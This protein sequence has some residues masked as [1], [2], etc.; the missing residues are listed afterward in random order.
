MAPPAPA[1]FS[2]VWGWA[3]PGASQAFVMI[4]RNL[5]HAPVRSLSAILGVGLGV[6]ILVGSLWV[7]PAMEEVID[8]TF[9]RAQRQ[10]AS[11]EFGE[12]TRIAALQEVARLPAVMQAEPYRSIPVTLRH[13][14]RARRV[15]LI[16][17][18]AGADLSRVL[19]L[20]H[21]P[22]DPPE[23]G[24]ALTEMLAKLLDA[25][26]GDLIEVEI[27]EGARRTV[28]APV[29]QVIP[30]YLGLGAYV[31]L[32]EANR[33]MRE[34]ALITGAHVTFDRAGTDAF[35]A[36][37]KEIPAARFIGLQYVSAARFRE[38][39]DRN[40]MT[41]VTIYGSLAAIIAFGVVYNS[42][43]IT[44]SERARDL[45]SLRV[46]GFTKG[47]VS[48]ILLTEL[49]VLV[50]L[51]QPLGWLLGLG[52]AQVLAAAFESEL[53]RVPLRTPPETFALA[54]LIVLAAAAVSALAVRRRI[55]RLDLIEVLKTRE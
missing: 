34:G 29:A 20:D 9:Q 45:A 18:P 16:G 50:A 3:P 14:W 30:G 23:S 40:L 53:Y 25:R 5:T 33:M 27:M 12:A 43:R 10:D 36:A 54:S 1:R 6:A 28:L 15:G 22:V 52:V 17:A 4:L 24:V 41:M 7:I 35:F 55:D 47:E 21:L 37:A 32:A 13:G 39:I 44:L 8:V 2:R 48:G 42:A 51:A 38:N 49:G 26:V 19:D 46:L 11:I 31:S